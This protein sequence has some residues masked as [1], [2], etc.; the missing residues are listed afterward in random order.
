LLL[1]LRESLPEVAD[2]VLTPQPQ[3]FTMPQTRPRGVTKERTSVGAIPEHD[4]V[5]GEVATRESS[6]GPGGRPDSIDMPIIVVDRDCKV[7]RFNQAAAEVLGSVP[8]DIGRRPCSVRALG[9]STGISSERA[10]K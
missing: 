1:A 10:S 7:A 4:R 8:S 5:Q 9:G 3:A 2:S 6:C